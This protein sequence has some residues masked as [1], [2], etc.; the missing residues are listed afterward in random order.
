VLVRPVNG[1]NLFGGCVAPLPAYISE[2]QLFTFV[3]CFNQPSPASGLNRTENIAL[4]RS[5]ASYIEYESKC[6]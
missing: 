5:A 2:R 3:F 6:R 4:A 1:E